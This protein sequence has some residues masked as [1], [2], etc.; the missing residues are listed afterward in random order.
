M[1]AAR[2]RELYDEGAK[3]RQKRKPA[4]SVPANLPEQTKTDAR[5]Q[6]GKA[7]GVSGKSVDYATNAPARPRG[8]HH[9]SHDESWRQHC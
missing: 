4:N 3:E 5:D 9:D 2:A 6:V 8:G 1:C 7:L